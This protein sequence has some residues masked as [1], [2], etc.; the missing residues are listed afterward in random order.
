MQH[1]ERKS[2]GAAEIVFRPDVG[3][4]N[5]LRGN[6]FGDRRFVGVVDDDEVVDGPTLGGQHFERLPQQLEATVGDH[7]PDH[8]VRGLRTT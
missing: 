5:A 4:G 6:Q 2:T 7:H 8:A 1:A 3:G